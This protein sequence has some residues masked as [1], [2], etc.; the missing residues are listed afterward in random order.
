MRM[1]FNIWLPNNFKRWEAREGYIK[2]SDKGP[3]FINIY[4]FVLEVVL[5]GNDDCK[6]PETWI[7]KQILKT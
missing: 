4:N 6:V 3:G 7:N 1:C 2:I 5:A